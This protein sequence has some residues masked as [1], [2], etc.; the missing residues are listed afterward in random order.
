MSGRAPDV[1]T[2]LRALVAFPLLGAALLGA[3]CRPNGAPPPSAGPAPGVSIGPESIV[4]VATV[5]APPGIVDP[6]SGN[7]SAS[8]TVPVVGDTTEAIPTLDPL[9]L[10]V[11][12][13]LLMLMA[14]P[15]IKAR[16]TTR[17]RSR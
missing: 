17:G 6:V 12:A 14:A 16:G 2:V 5:T 7:G 10:A 15:A 11:L 1:V 8:A 4:N 3:A 13:M 9:A